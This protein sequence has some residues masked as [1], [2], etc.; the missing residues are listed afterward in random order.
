M[1]H[2]L[3]RRTLAKTAGA[4]TGSAAAGRIA[5]AVAQGATPVAQDAT[6]Q[7]GFPVVELPEGYQIE[8]V[9]EGLT[10]PTG[11]TWDSA[12]H[13]YVAEAGGAFLDLGAPSRILQI[14]N[15]QATEVANLTETVGTIASV[16]GL[17]WYN[18]AF[19]FTH[20]DPD[21]RTGAVSRL[22]SDGQVTQ[23]FS[24]IVDH[25]AEHQINDI[26]MGPDGRM[27]VASGPAGNAAVVGL[28]LAPFVM[29]SPDVHT[30]PCE[31]IVLTGRNYVTP[32]FRSDNPYETVMTG[33]YVPFGTETMPGQVIEGTVKC[34]GAILVF[35]PENE[36]PEGTLAVHAWG[37]RNVI[38]LAW[39]PE[40]VMYAA[41]NGYDIRGSRPVQDEFDPTYRIE[42]GTWYGWPDFSAALE[43]LTDPKFGVPGALQPPVMIEGQPVNAEAPGFVIDHE[44]SGLQVADASLIAGLHDWNSSPSMLDVAP[45]SWNEFAG[46]LFVAEWGDLAPPT[47]PLRDEPK[48]S[49]IVRID[50]QSGDVVPFAQTAKPGPASAQMAMGMGLERPFDVKFG[51]DGAMYIVDYGVARINPASEGTPYAFPPETGI[52]WK[53]TPTDGATGTPA[54]V[55]SEALEE[56]LTPE[57]TEGPLEEILTPEP[58]EEGS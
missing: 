26:R 4:L 55:E 13:M 54:A 39:D 34:G 28:D 1:D 19:Y 48:G 57:P 10:Y 46:Q 35:E 25:Q 31:D 40:G 9:V 18:D 29:L 8:K 20:R 27:Y 15:G 16:V 56:I 7:A 43:P 21:D 12:G 30:T 23:L 44:A 2:K 11:L 38:G 49:R 37:L 33:A 42:E 22:T 52:I 14:E 32:D 53:I 6:P 50:P 47:N 24:G 45:Q 36:N 51:P 41:V 3:N 5:P 58:T 17:F